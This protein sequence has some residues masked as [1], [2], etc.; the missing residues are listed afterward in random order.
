M[1]VRFAFSICCLLSAG[2]L[3]GCSPSA[4]RA[5]PAV[6]PSG[7]PVP[8]KPPAPVPTWTNSAQDA[9]LLGEPTAVG[10]FEM[11]GPK[12]FKFRTLPGNSFLWNGSPREDE[13]FATIIAVLVALPPEPMARSL[14]SYMEEITAPV[15][16]QHKDCTV[17]ATERGTINGVPFVRV[18]W[19][20]IGADIARPKLQGRELNGV[21][22]FT[23]RDGQALQV[24][25]QDAAPHHERTLQLG[26]AA[27][28][29]LRPVEK[30]GP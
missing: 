5:A 20:G 7:V 18:R 8:P 16:A 3:T 12:D 2:A 4:P 11:R 24:L 25:C 26:T 21:I 14:E 1:S 29:S 30:T 17:S 28:H 9:E 22:Y 6:A 27:A 23:V 10:P 19:K 13:T 15:K